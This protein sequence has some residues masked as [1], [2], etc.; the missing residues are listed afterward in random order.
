M[1]HVINFSFHDRWSTTGKAVLRD[2]LSIMAREWHKI[3]ELRLKNIH[4]KC[5]RGFHLSSRSQNRWWTEIWQVEPII[6]SL[7]TISPSQTTLWQ[8]RSSLKDH[9]FGR[10]SFEDL[11][12]RSQTQST[13]NTE[14]ILMKGK[15]DRGTMKK[16][17]L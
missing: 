9:F 17:K 13:M 11:Q 2:I 16:N 8:T 6:N 10:N 15:R 12:Y 3:F 5:T 7:Q 1:W 14:Y 4:L